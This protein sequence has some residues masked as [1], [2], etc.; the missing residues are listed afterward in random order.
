MITAVEVGRG[1][2]LFLVFAPAAVRAARWLV[3]EPAGPVGA[4]I[5]LV[6]LVALLQGL[7]RL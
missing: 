3:S 6:V 2:L 4:V 1:A 7:A 5:R